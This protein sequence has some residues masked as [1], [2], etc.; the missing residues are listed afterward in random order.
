[1]YNKEDLLFWKLADFFIVQSGYRIVKLFPDQR[2]LWLEKKENK[3][4]PIIRLLRNDVAWSNW[5]ARDIESTAL[6]GSRIRQ[7]MN[8]REMPLINIYV[9]EHPPVDD[10]EDAVGKPF[11]Y[12]DRMSETRVHSILFA[13]GTYKDAEQALANLDAFGDLD[14]INK[15]DN[16]VDPEEI[17]KHAL[18]HAKKEA[19][20]EQ[21][22]FKAGKPFFTY[23]FLA[24]QIAVFLILEVKGGSTN[25]STLLKFGAK[26]NPLILEGEWWRFLTPIFLHI[27]FLHLIMN[28]FGL[29]FVGTAVERIM[30]SA[31]FLFVYLFAGFGGS[32][33]SFLFS[34]EV[35][36]GASG[37]IFGCLG[38]LLYFGLVFPRLFYRTMGPTVIFIIILNLVFGFSVAMVDNAGHL[39]GLAAGF[40]GAGIVHFPK[41]R[42]LF[43]QFSFAAVSILLT[44]LLLQ[45]GFDKGLGPKDERSVILLAEGYISNENYEQANKVLKKYEANTSVTEKTYFMLSFAEIKLGQFPEAK[46][47]LQKAI[48][49]KPDFPEGHYNLALV[50]L[51]EENVKAA[52]EHAE[53]AVALKPGEKEYE[54]L[55]DQLRKAML[56]GY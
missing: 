56:E 46:I 21:A 47:N 13:E 3:K 11:I 28:S 4:A 32:L 36:A 33:A 42:K 48:D 1:M 43:L 25:P 8:R 45:Y 14:F 18:V 17:K 44:V 41:K 50:Y 52:L 30:G 29:Y 2:E 20:K 7:Q 27:G 9:S 51:E 15:L 39:G 26:F 55:A 37:A 10:Y 19:E 12:Q 16:P 24:I 49:L 6:T 31:R 54:D 34:H 23:I 38:A 35:S 40:L 53:K 22:V 5:M